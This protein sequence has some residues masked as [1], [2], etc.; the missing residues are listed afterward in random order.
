MGITI[1]AGFIAAAAFALIYRVPRGE[2]VHC[3]L[4][5]AGGW[6]VFSSARLIG[7]V[8]AYFLASA[9]VALISEV[10]ARQRYQPVIVYL[11]PGVIPL[12]PGGMAYTTMMHFLH[13]E[14]G[15]GLELMAATFFAAGAIAGGITVVSSGFRVFS[16]RKNRQRK[17]G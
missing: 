11:I 6:L 7:E 2:I 15:A 4:V 8:G 12:V 10:L 9:A 14:Y 16:A 17:S 5:G 1:A 13:N 3:G